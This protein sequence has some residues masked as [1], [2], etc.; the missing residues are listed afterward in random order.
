MNASL[1]TKYI[2]IDGVEHWSLEHFKQILGFDVD[3]SGHMW[4]AT[5]MQNRKT[6][7]EQNLPFIDYDF[8][9]LA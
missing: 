4:I 2:Q 1:S 9:S 8:E 5:F 6:R 3:N 7:I